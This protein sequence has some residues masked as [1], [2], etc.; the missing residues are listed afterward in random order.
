MTERDFS[1]VYS[2]IQSVTGC[3]TQVKIAEC[4]GV[5][6][7]SISDAKTRGAV[8]GGWLLTLLERHRCNPRW[9]LTGQGPRYLVPA[10]AESVPEPDAMSQLNS[11]ALDAA[12][13]AA[14]RDASARI[15]NDV[16]ELAGLQ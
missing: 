10:E 7:S 3:K 16:R 1:A 13:D 5:Q 2:R 9:L 11:P 14:L 4:L 6:Q 15:A 12:I 8:P